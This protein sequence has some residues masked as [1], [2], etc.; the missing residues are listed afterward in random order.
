MSR[1]VLAILLLAQAVFGPVLA[2]REQRLQHAQQTVA[3]VE[4]CACSAGS[5]ECCC[6]ESCP[7]PEAPAPRGGSCRCTVPLATP[8]VVVV[9]AERKRDP[10]VRRDVVKS[11][12]P[13][14]FG[15]RV[16][17]VVQAA[18]MLEVVGHPHASIVWT[19]R[20]TT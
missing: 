6:C 18:P 13:A 19:G 8:T 17:V 4:A 20:R 7:M 12:G 11:R 15:A 10:P 2:L 5:C 16:S 9:Q 1:V 14:T 3:V